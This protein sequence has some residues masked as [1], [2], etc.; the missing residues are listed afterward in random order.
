MRRAI[1]GVVL[2]VSATGAVPAHAAPV[3]AD[4]PATGTA[5]AVITHDPR[6]DEAPLP[7]STRAALDI[8]MDRAL[9][10]PAEFSVPYAEFDTVV[11]P[12]RTTAAQAAVDAA[13]AAMTVAASPLGLGSDDGSIPDDGV[14]EKPAAEANAFSA[15]QAGPTMTVRPHV[16]KVRYSLAELDQVQQEVLQTSL[17]GGDKLRTAYVDAPNNRVLVKASEVTQELREA[18]AARYGADRV[19]L[20]LVPGMA[21]PVLKDNRQDDSSPYYGGAYFDYCTTAFGWVHEGKSYILTAGHCTS[22]NTSASNNNGTMGTVTAD[23]WNNNTGSVK[24]NGQSYYSGDVSTIKMSSGKASSHR[25]YRGG[26]NSGQSRAVTDKWRNR[27]GN[28]DRYCV[29]GQRTGE[30]CGWKVISTYVTVRFSGNKVLRNATEGHRDGTCTRGG[31][32]GAP[33]YTIR[34]DGGVAAKGVLSG[35]SSNTSGSCWDYF[36]DTSLAEKALAGVLRVQAPR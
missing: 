32:S 20:Y 34:S 6:E 13:S 2:A 17:P 28:G 33:I 3:T 36:T 31:D 27:S 23:N 35:G 16:S 14:A 24:W 21:E 8:A 18:L 25:V 12:V 10:N 15:Q 5:V 29:S 4:Q 26:T 22:L 1:A 19:A 9:A 30:M 7:D 11:A